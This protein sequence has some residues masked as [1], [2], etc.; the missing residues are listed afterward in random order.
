MP[1]F[2]EFIALLTAAVW[3]ATSMVF[4]A[5]AARI[6]SVQVNINRMILAVALLG[7]SIWAFRIP[8]NLSYR[9]IMYLALSAVVGIVFGDTFLFKAFQQIGARLSMLIM[10]LAP[11]I[12]AILAYLFLHEVLSGWA[13]V[14]M[15]VTLGGI[16]LVIL[17]RTA[18]T[19]SQ[20]A[21]TKFGIGCGFF[22]ALGQGGGVVLVKQAFLEGP[23][24]G[25]VATFVRLSASLLIMLPVAAALGRYRNPVRVFAP[26]RKLLGLMLIGAFFGTYIGITLSLVAVAHAQVGVASTLIATSPVLMLPMV[27]FLHKEPLSWKAVAGALIAVSGVALLFLG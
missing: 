24:H 23:I 19:P 3:A 2:G 22:A 8:V 5:V 14:G 11:A 27:R 21:I 6:G 18:P 20:R 17:E 9:Q 15:V 25:F 1:F 12:A 7:L 10:S 16:V 26:D 13:I 4:A